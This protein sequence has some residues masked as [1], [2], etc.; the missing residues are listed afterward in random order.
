METKPLAW[1][2]M[3]RGNF[4]CEC[5]CACVNVHVHVCAHK[6][7]CMCVC[8]LDIGGDWRGR[9]DYE[10]EV[11]TELCVSQSLSSSEGSIIVF[12]SSDNHGEKLEPNGLKAVMGTGLE[13]VNSKHC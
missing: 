6:H 13:Y 5:A 4:V 7:V 1:G 2:L 3:L 11:K 8:V 9:K 10:K 12:R